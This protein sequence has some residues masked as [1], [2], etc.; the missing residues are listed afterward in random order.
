MDMRRA[1]QELAVGKI[2][3]QGVLIRLLVIFWISK[4]VT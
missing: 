1:T 3:S 2:V 4:R